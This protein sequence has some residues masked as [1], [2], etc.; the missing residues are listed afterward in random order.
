VAYNI[1]WSGCWAF[2]WLSIGSVVIVVTEL[3]NVVVS[4]FVV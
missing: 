4:G 1:D 3:P 2:G